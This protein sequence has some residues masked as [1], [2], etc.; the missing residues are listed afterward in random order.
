[1]YN[2]HCSDSWVI[3]SCNV[4]MKI[5]WLINLIMHGKECIGSDEVFTV[6]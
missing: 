4:L 2:M 3:A 5:P 1:M 6:Y